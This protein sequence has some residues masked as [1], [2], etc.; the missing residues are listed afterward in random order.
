[1]LCICTC[2]VGLV[3]FF[4][5]VILW[6]CW[7]QLCNHFMWLLPQQVGVVH[8][9]NINR[10]LGCK[11]VLT[12]SLAVHLYTAVSNYL[13]FITEMRDKGVSPTDTE[14]P[15]VPSP[16]APQPLP[17]SPTSADASETPVPETVSRLTNHNLLCLVR[18]VVGD[19]NSWNETKGFIVSRGLRSATDIHES[20]RV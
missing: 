16:P 9:H 19:R 17:P 15:L 3:Y 1:M 13:P 14:T 8:S 6:G 7:V 18:T 10:I 11:R 5:A 20:F 4:L 2:V 12:V